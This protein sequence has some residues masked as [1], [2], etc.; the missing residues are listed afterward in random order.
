MADQSI[1]QLGVATALTG[2]ELTV[3]V[4]NGVTKQTQVQDIANLGGGG[5]PAGP[6]GSVAVGDGTGLDYTAIGTAGQVLTSNGTATPTWQT[7]AIP[8]TPPIPLNQT[9]I[10]ANTAIPSNYNGASL[11]PV[12]VDTGVTVT[13]PTGSRWQI[14]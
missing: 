5:V 8:S 11:G 7:S 14:N 13:I 3:V 12:T 6:V 2:T 9:V 1:S 10:N 4:Q